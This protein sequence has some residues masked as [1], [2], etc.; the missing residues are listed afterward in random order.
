MARACWRKDRF[1][2]NLMSLGIYRQLESLEPGFL[3][4]DTK[5]YLER[6]GRPSGYFANLTDAPLIDQ[7]LVKTS[8][9]P[10]RKTDLIIAKR[11]PH[12]TK[13]AEQS[14]CNY[15]PFAE[16]IAAKRDIRFG[17]ICD[18]FDTIAVIP[19]HGFGEGSRLQWLNAWWP[20]GRGRKTHPWNTYRIP[21]NVKKNKKNSLI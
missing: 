13:V 14:V 6:R 10:E 19:G 17:Q 12:Q 1:G 21:P 16:H 4:S 2:P 9:S 20:G 8:V 11:T 7:R 18:R 15:N 3:R 5:K